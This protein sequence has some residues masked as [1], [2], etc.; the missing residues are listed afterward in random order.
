[1]TVACGNAVGGNE[2]ETLCPAISFRFDRA[3]DV[4]SGRT[5][6]D[7]DVRTTTKKLLKELYGDSWIEQAPRG[8][9]DEARIVSRT[10]SASS[11]RT[12]TDTQVAGAV[13]AFQK[14]KE[15]AMDRC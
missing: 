5:P 8:F 13:D 2:T 7:A 11:S 3:L 12:L 1:M 6:R 4:A 15:A 14:V 9:R 10:A